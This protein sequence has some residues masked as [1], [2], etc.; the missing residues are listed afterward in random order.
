VGL[1]IS[2]SDY[3]K[4][5]NSQQMLVSGDYSIG[6]VSQTAI[7][8][9]AYPVM[10]SSDRST[11]FLL[12]SLSLD[13]LVEVA[14]QSELPEESALLVVDQDGLIL[15]RYPDPEEWL[16]SIIPDSPVIGAMLE[17]R[18]DGTAE[19]EGVDGVERIYAFVPL[20]QSLDEEAYLGI[21]I[22]TEAAYAAVNKDLSR[23]LVNLALVTILAVGLSWSASDRF[24]VHPF[25]R[26]IGVTRR[27][28][29]GDADIR[30]E[31]SQAYGELKR[32]GEA[33]NAM[34]GS[35]QK[36]DQQLRQAEHRYRTLV[37][38][39]PAVIYTAEAA[40]GYPRTY[41][42]PQVEDVFGYL[43]DEWVSDRGL[44]IR[45]IHPE[46]RQE[47]IAELDRSVRSK[48]IFQ[49]EYRILTRTGVERWVRDEALPLLDDDGSILFIQ[50]ILLDITER[51]NQ[52]EAL[53]QYSIQLEQ[54]NRELQDFA[55]I[56]S[57]DLQEPLRKIQ[58]FGERIEVKYGQNLPEEGTDYLRRMRSS[59]ERLQNLINDLL[60][61]SRVSTRGKP[62]E[63][64][65]LNK[66]VSEVINDLGERIQETGGR[67]EVE[68]L[69]RIEADPSQMRQLFQNLI[70]NALKFHRQEVPPVVKIFSSQVHDGRGHQLVQICV[71]DNGIGFDEK[72]LDRIF[73]PFQRLHARGRYEGSGI[74][75]AICRKIAERHGGDI[76][77]R[78]TPE[79]GATFIVTL[80]VQQT[81]RDRSRI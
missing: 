47:V 39:I 59:A 43:P 38:Q 30:A 70:A 35:L 52:E 74:G 28:A 12:V 15:A 63:A 34:A 44:W 19:V 73:Q 69:P 6:R 49:T 1:D 5:A 27:L 9:F 21:G 76:S 62:F 75:L 11:R 66:V 56:A 41:T 50:G 64:I 80:P 33:F 29:A 4:E 71:E 54:S 23:N 31:T 25:N 55:Y 36:R 65:Q 42:S 8:P 57:H 18:S 46:D 26:L 40:E 45:Q 7:L 3:F 10:E 78:S 2:Q 72:Y 81:K 37:E 68:P 24:I 16:G 58:A 51:K 32:L 77:A 53:E 48:Q 14:S 79:I 13:H 22:P 61:F 60:T 20:R 17:K 67:V